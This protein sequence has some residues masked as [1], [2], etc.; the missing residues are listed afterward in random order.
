MEIGTYSLR[1][2]LTN[3]L[4]PAGP[5]SET[6]LLE[7]Q[8][9]IDGPKDTPYKV[10]SSSLA[11]D[12]KA[13][14]TFGLQGGK[15]NITLSFPQDYPFTPPAF[16]FLTPIYHPNVDDQ[17][18]IC[19]S[20]LKEAEW[21]PSTRVTAILEGVLGLLVTPNPDD[22]LV[23]SIAETYINNRYSFRCMKLMVGNCLIRLQGIMLGNM[24]CEII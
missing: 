17:G 22:P 2:S 3:L 9:T 1:V 19:L 6:N 24:L 21:K 8:G 11:F 12:L 16:K 10:L 14:T 7:W 23:A 15:F 13:N 20:L 5:T 18:A 4:S